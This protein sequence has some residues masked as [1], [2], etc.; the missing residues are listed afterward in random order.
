MASPSPLDPLDRIVIAYLAVPL[1]IFLA[2]WFEA[3]AAVPLLA[4][5]AYALKALLS[6]L[7]GA[8]ARWPVTRL[9]LSVALAVGCAWTVCGGIGHWVFANADWHLRDAVLHDLVAGQWPVGYGVVGGKD[10]L[11]RAPLGYYLPAALLGKC[12][13]LLAAHAALAAWTM[14][15]AVLFL[16]QVLSLTPSRAGV[17]LA[18]AAVIVCFS[19]LDVLGYLWRAPHLAA[20]W[21]ITRHLEWWA[22]SY[23]YSSMTTQLFWV[24]NHALGG[25]LTIGLL[26]RGE[27]DTPL[28]SM[29]PM[30]VVAVALWSPLAALGAVPFVLWKLAARTARDPGAGLLH[31]RVWAPALAVGLAVGAYLTLDAGRIPKGWT[32]GRSGTG[33]SA[34][35]MDLL[36]QGQFFLLEAGLIGIAILGVRRRG[37]VVLALAV[38]ALL[39]LVSF[40]SANDLCMRA[41]IPSL[42]VLAIGACLALFRDA[43]APGARGKKAA[44]GCLLAVGAVTPFQEFARAAV[45]PAWPADLSASLIGAACGRYPA[46]YVARLGG[47]AIEHVL[48]GPRVLAQEP[49]RSPTCAKPGST[50]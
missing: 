23:Q 12:S 22:D 48:R 21:D 24:P 20:H 34:I 11:L 31:P 26:F 30:I 32:L 49:P 37:Q 8:P 43:P 16:L 41:S 25:W 42:A 33:P 40:G 44:L 50:S 1:V 2:G 29:L 45:L 9:Q 7:P 17:A 39:P 14:I 27:R 5:L 4:C 36:H 10:S 19:G 6:G 15:G 35:A 18:V 47:H 3:W 38:L 28:D 13:G 46:H